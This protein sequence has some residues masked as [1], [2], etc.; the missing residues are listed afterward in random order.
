MTPVLATH[1]A[2]GALGILTGTLAISFRKGGEAHRVFGTVFTLAMLIMSA[3]GV[4]L[5]AIMPTTSVV[6]PGP[7]AI[8]GAFTFYLVASA[9]LTVARRPGEI[10]LLERAGLLAAIG[11]TT[12]LLALG[13]AVALS[14]SPAPPPGIAPYFVFA[15]LTAIAA[16][17]DLN[18]IRK[19]G[20]TGTSRI[21]R[22]L[23]RMCLAFFF[24]TSFFF[25][26]Q[27]KVMPAYMH[28]S[29][30]LFALGLAPLAPLLFWLIAIRLMKRFRADLQPA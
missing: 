9:W 28:R 13:T 3:A 5:A 27:Q 29:P 10:G 16:A 11:A 1:V 30:I 8:I 20:L 24:A 17:G 7:T 22:H 21:A 15:V 23:W 19:R 12:G 26:G 2:L 25:I 14:A 18:L 6:P 4:Y